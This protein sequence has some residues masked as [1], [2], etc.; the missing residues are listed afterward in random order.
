MTD[1]IAALAQRNL[2]DVFG[3]RDPQARAEAIRDVYAEDVTFADP[4]EV[5]VGWDA[6]NAKA[7]RLLDEAPDFVFTPVGKVRVV[8]DLAY[9]AWHLGPA[10]AAPAVSGA[11]VSLVKDGRITHLW[12]ILDAPAGPAA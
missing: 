4:D 1:H 9:L 11:D 6:L 7:Q 2:L 8:Q 5:V 12:T 10:G 3:Q